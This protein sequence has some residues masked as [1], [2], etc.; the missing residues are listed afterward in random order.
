MAEAI[1]R[2]HLALARAEFK[3]KFPAENNQEFNK[4]GL[5]SPT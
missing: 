2:R 1:M 5:F 3:R 4:K